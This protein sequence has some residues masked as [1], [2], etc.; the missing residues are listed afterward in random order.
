M[1]LTSRVINLFSA[2]TGAQQSRNEIGFADDGLSGGK[3]TFP[4]VK[5]GAEVFG[6]ENMT[7]GTYD[8]E[9]RPA[10]IHVSTSSYSWRIWTDECSV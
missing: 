7:P 3:Q 9:P 5:L 2:S 8:E 4:D 10:Y 6:V 1:S